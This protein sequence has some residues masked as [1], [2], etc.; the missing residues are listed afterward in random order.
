MK[1]SIRQS[2]T[3]SALMLMFFTQ[4]TYAAPGMSEQQMQQMMLNAQKAQACFSEFDK[5]TFDEL[6]AKGKKMEA[7]IKA[8]CAAGKRD[9][10][11]STAMKY[12]KQMHND[13]KM[14]EIR[15]CGEMMEGAMAGMPQP[16]MPPTDEEQE[17]DGHICDD[18]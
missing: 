10:A 9:E 2:L 7:D 14:K 1:L 13:P 8:L 6:E 3:Y 15:K 12:S 4:T 11:M 5:S 16:Y 18:M 17:K